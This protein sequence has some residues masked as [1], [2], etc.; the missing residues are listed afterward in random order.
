M[1]LQILLPIID[2]VSIIFF[3]DVMQHKE[4][5]AAASPEYE[6]SSYF[7]HT[8]EFID[9]ADFAVANMEFSLGGKPY[10]GYPNFSAPEELPEEALNSGI[11]LFLCAN[12]HICD[13]G[14]KGLAR[15][16]DE[17]EKMNAEI[18]GIYRDSTDEADNNPYI[19]YI[20]G[21]K[22]AFIN[23]TFSTNGIP[24]SP[25]YIVN[26]MDKQKILTAIERAEKENAQIIIALPHWGDEY[27]TEPSSFQRDWNEFLLKNGVDAIIGSHPHVVQPTETIINEDN[28]RQTT[29][30]SM[31]NYVSNM[32]LENTEIG[33]AFI[34]KIA[35]TMFN[36][37]Y[38]AGC[39]TI[40]LWCSRPGGLN[41]NYTVIPVENYIDK[42]EEF[43]GEWNYRKMENTYKRLKTLF[44]NNEQRIDN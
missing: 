15:T 20:K 11:N 40:A 2:T 28:S 37:A 22:F 12:N 6:Y 10:S 14:T 24:F 41:G 19:A 8:K 17:Y 42:K 5:L 23:F 3:G 36:Q 18:T 30:Y 32:S 4:Q 29:I 43:A 1:L 9:A 16:I 35:K 33:A 44:N 26:L 21:I 25:P 38:V 13:R 27:R 7:E 34:L 31:G 39:E